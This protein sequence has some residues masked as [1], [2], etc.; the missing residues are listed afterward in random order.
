[1]IA[2]TE[3]NKCLLEARIESLEGVLRDWGYDDV[4]GWWGDDG[5]RLPASPPEEDEDCHDEPHDSGNRKNEAS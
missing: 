3:E 1:M 5:N 2:T 4:Y